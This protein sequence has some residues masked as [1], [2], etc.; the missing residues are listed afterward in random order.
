MGGSGVQSPAGYTGSS[1]PAWEVGDPAKDGEKEGGAGGGD[2]DTGTKLFLRPGS[3]SFLPA[4][5]SQIMS[6]IHKPIIS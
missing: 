6:T 1:R 3:G 2:E 4:A 5:E